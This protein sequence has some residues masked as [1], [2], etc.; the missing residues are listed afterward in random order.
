MAAT[1]GAIFAELANPATFAGLLAKSTRRV[2]QADLAPAP[3]NQAVTL[4]CDIAAHVQ[5]ATNHMRLGFTKTK[6]V[7]TLM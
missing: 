1:F 7:K 6:I 2:T 5:A 3:P 4:E